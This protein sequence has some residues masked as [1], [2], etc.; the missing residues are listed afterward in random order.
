MDFLINYGFFL[1][2]TVTIVIA[3]LVVIA[4]I[5]ALKAKA[6]AALEMGSLD[7]QSLNEK[8][9]ELADAMNECTLTKAEK[10]A[11]K[12]NT[13]NKKTD[14]KSKRLFVLRFDGDIKASGVDALR[15]S[16]TAILL[17][18]SQEDEVLLCL[19]SGGGMVP[20]Y[21]LAA[22]Q[23]QRIRNANIALTV[24]IDK[25]A[26][27]GG[28]MM[29]CVANQII[30]APFAIIGSI[31]VVAQLPNFHRLLKK[32]DIDFEQ[33][34]AGEYKRTLTLFGE[35]TKEGREKLQSEINDTHALFKSFVGMHRPEVVIDNIATG[36][37]WY[38]TQCLERK[39]VDSIQ[40]S[41]DY[42]LSKKTSHQLFEVNYKVKQ[43]L[44]KRFNFL[45]R[46]LFLG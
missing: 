34:T 26:A 2:K 3:I 35:N 36:E 24:A 5:V 17:S 45:A 14:E 33:I 13:K 38:A 37:H 42:L 18:A 9:D 22:S 8:Y 7:I 43:S 21:G 31:G 46:Q 23:L 20:H 27:S 25:I 10:K 41:D 28:Y 30:A 40:T 39:L 44:L 15:E 19:E 32:N 6:K 12:K 11:K 1:A 16:I 29:A 4:A